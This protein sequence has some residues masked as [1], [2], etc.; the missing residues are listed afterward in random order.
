[1][2]YLLFIS[3][4]ISK[5]MDHILKD[6]KVSAQVCETIRLKSISKPDFIKIIN[7]TAGNSHQLR[8]DL[9]KESGLQLHQIIA[10]C[11]RIKL[12][13]RK[14]QQFMQTPSVNNRPNPFLSS[15]NTSNAMKI[16]SGGT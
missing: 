2:A 14:D 3:R 8:V 15:M 4:G 5:N 7:S 11:D 10:I 13:S 6:L 16:G 9:S 12:E 1:V